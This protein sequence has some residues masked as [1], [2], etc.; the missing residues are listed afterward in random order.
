MEVKIIRYLTVENGEPAVE[1]ECSGTP[2]LGSGPVVRLTEGRSGEE[3]IAHI[4]E[5]EAI[6][7]NFAASGEIVDRP[8]PGSLAERMHYEAGIIPGY[9]P[10]PAR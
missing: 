9:P 5:Q 2:H 7:D 8:P 1:Y 6:K 10:A 4:K 3:L